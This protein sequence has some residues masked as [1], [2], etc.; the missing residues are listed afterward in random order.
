MKTE[1]LYIVWAHPR[2]DSLTANVVKE[3]HDQAVSQGIN[4]ASLDLY[5]SNFES[6]LSIDDEPDWHNAAKQYSPDIHRLFAELDAHDTVVMVFP[7]WWFSFPAIMKGYL[8]RVWTNGLAYGEGSTLKGKKFRYVAL[9]GGTESG[10]KKYGWEKNM[11][12]YAI[13]MMSYLGVDDTKI[14]FLYNTIGLEEEISE[15]H[16]QQLFAQARGIISE[17]AN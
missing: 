3:I 9:A 4:V 15:G 10:F 14:D 13:G 12:D 1:K 17:L 7:V 16:Y 2:A 8:D 6:V 11:T 5:R